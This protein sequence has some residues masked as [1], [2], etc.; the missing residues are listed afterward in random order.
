MGII[1][2][3]RLDEKVALVTGGGRGIGKAYCLSLAEAGADVAVVDLD[4]DTAK[5]TALEVSNRGRT[6]FS[7]K[8]DVTKPGLVHSMIQDVI[9]KF[10]RLDIAVNNAGGVRSA[11]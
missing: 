1:D 9:K 8:V 5:Q 2:K 10:G 11:R 7:L 6:G 4:E 3:F